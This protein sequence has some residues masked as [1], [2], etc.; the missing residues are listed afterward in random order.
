VAARAVTGVPGRTLPYRCCAGLA[1]A[2]PRLAT[3]RSPGA[4]PNPSAHPPF[5]APP[6]PLLLLTGLPEQRHR[7]PGLLPGG[8]PGETL[9]AATRTPAGSRAHRVRL[10]L[11][12]RQAPAAVMPAA[13]RD[14]EV[15]AAASTLAVCYCLPCNTSQWS[16]ICPCGPPTTHACQLDDGTPTHPLSSHIHHA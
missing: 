9:L 7:A 5:N 2:A 12:L 10:A 1:H 6:S 3:T 16:S 14:V 11:V 13:T 8:I 4:A 15:L